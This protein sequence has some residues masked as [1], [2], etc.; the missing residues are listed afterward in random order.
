VEVV[1]LSAEGGGKEM[2]FHD[3]Q[4]R[5][6]M[7]DHAIIFRALG[8][9]GEPGVEDALQK[10]DKVMEYAKGHALRYETNER[11]Y[12]RAEGGHHRIDAVIISLQEGKRTR[13]RRKTAPM[14]DRRRLPQQKP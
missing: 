5:I 10:V 11:K 8:E 4:L 1:I 13:D 2:Q 14:Q 6:E 3:G 9:N 12:A 7:L